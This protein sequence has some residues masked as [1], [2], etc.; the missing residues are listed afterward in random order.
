M[1]EKIAAS[2]SEPS[3]SS[4]YT[5]SIT[6][7]NAKEII[8][9][10]RQS[11]E[12]IPNLDIVNQWLRQIDKIKVASNDVVI[13]VVGATGSGKSS[14]INALSDELQ[15]IPTNCMRACTAVVT[16]I[17]WNDQ[18]GAPWRATIEFLKR[19]EW[20]KELEALLGDL[21]TAAGSIY[22][23]GS[24]A[25][26]AFSK[27]TAVYPHLNK[28]NISTIDINTLMSE[29]E[30]SRYLETD[31]GLDADNGQ[32][33]HDQIKSFIDSKEKLGLHYAQGGMANAETSKAMDD[34]G[35]WPLIRRVRI[36]G[37]AAVLAS[38][39]IL[40]D[41]PGVADSNAARGAIAK[42]YLE[43]CSALSVVASIIRAVDERQ[44]D[45]CS[46]HD[47]NVSYIATERCLEL[48]SSAP[49]PMKL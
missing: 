24:E 16:E 36:F 6:I 25:G 15:L 19:S 28:S 23:E 3:S 44:L 13:G 14:I 20:R 27:I 30:V 45:I 37:R 38:G 32:N 34:I 29:E 12:A 11:F 31:I 21:E 9:E 35:Y 48:V 17:M 7:D 47:S 26:V 39:A 5:L 42:E 22:D 2:S 4:S 41:L 43:K 18:P 33:L 10:L 40:V 49:N 1:A 46:A 8:A